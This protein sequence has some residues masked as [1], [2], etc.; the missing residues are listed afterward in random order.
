V[1]ESSL[2]L[3]HSSAGYQPFEPETSYCNKDK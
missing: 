2:R 1:V 3:K